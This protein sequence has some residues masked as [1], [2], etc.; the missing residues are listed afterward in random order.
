MLF[1]FCARSCTCIFMLSLVVGFAFM[2]QAQ[3]SGNALLPHGPFMNGGFEDNLDGWAW[4]VSLGAEATAGV[5]RE[6]SYGGQQSLR[7]TN[8]TPSKPHTYG[9]LRRMVT[10]LEPNT[11]YRVTAWAKG[12]NVQKCQLGGG[13]GWEYRQPFPNGTYDW[14]RIE[15]LIG[16]KEAT[17]F[18]L[19]IVTGDLVGAIWIDDIRFV[20]QS[21]DPSVEVAEAS[22]RIGDDVDRPT[23]D[24]DDVPLIDGEYTP[25]QIFVPGPLDQV[26]SYRLMGTS[27]S[28]SEIELA[29]F[30]IPALSAAQTA[31]VA[32]AIQSR[33]LPKHGRWTILLHEDQNESPV[34]EA[35][36]TYIDLEGDTLALLETLKGRQRL[37][38]TQLAA[39][40]TF[41]RSLYVQVYAGIADHYINRIEKRH[42]KD[43]WWSLLQAQQVGYIYDQLDSW[44]ASGEPAAWP[45]HDLAMKPI[46]SMTYKTGRLTARRQGETQDIP[47][48]ATGYGHFM[49]VNKDLPMLADW[50]ITALAKGSGPGQ[51]VLTADG[52]FADGNHKARLA[53]DAIELADK[54]HVVAD[55]MASPHAMPAWFEEQHPDALVH[56]TGFIGFDIDHPAA[57]QLVRD[58]YALITPEIAR[59]DN[60]ISIGL[61]NEPRYIRG[62]QTD[63]GRPAYL[64]FLR[65]R[66]GSITQVNEL[67][68]TSYSSFD[69]LPRPGMDGSDDIGRRRAAFDWIEFNTKHFADWH[70]WM[71]G[72]VADVAPDLPTYTKLVELNWNAGGLREGVDPEMMC[73]A[74]DLAG[75]DSRFYPTPDGEFMLDWHTQTIW[76][77]LLHSF[78]NQP[79]INTEHHV[80]P[81]GLKESI[82]PKHVRAGLWQSALH[83]LQFSTMWIWDEPI[84]RHFEG[85]IYLR[86]AVVAETQ[87][88]MLDA[89]RLAVELAAVADAP[90]RVALLYST[91]SLFWDDTAY[92]HT[93]E[94]V[95]KALILRGYVPTFISERQLA[96]GQASRFNVIILPQAG[97][98]RSEALVA[99]GEYASAGGNVLA[100]GTP[101]RFDEYHRPAILPTGLAAVESADVPHDD[102]ALADDLANRLTNFGVVA[103]RL[104]D[105]ADGQPAWGVEYRVVTEDDGDLVAFMN[106]N[107]QPCTVQLHREG[108]GVDL[109]SGRAISFERFELDPLEPVLIR[110]AK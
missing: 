87:R 82:P 110:V 67:Y 24:L 57:R 35:M 2:A 104:T 59:H 18:E 102:H 79:V 61:S 29:V 95:H 98:M 58:W 49:Q 47:F 1:S 94:R 13:P 101:P 97:H 74:T 4:S 96:Q 103:P 23:V 91:S 5:D 15:M 32:F 30:D 38:S 37:I 60:V 92:G 20:K 33:A 65:G 11:T 8:G 66:H 72:L 99:L 89:R 3:V 80:I 39:E 45:S 17:Q 53:M 16:T 77:D 19:I 62:G 7:I 108:G 12:Q 50:G 107:R 55:F 21:D 86:P 100:L 56:N 26:V 31:R 46:E 52:R 78:R 88:T 48:Y 25:G 43:P 44:I 28:G 70:A 106:Y 68:R 34:A 90:K 9:V 10:G 6:V 84:H 93:A 83:H 54:H 22:V 81:N 75:C 40:T 14:Q 76:F 41:A 51:G 69:D 36:L 71:D 109:I 85:S 42:S 27:G 63:Y 73:L 64:D 105:L